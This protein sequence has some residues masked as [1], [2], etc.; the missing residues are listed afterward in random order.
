MRFANEECKAVALTGRGVA[1]RAKIRVEVRAINR[2]AFMEEA[3][4]TRWIVQIENGCLN[5]CVGRASAGRMQWIAF[6]L[7]RTPVHSRRDQRN[8]AGASG[9]GCRVVQKF[10]GYGPLDALRERHQMQF[11]SATTGQADSGE[12][13]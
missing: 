12:R 6:Q 1:Q 10:S 11:R 13:H 5:E 9:H 4:G 8:C 3:S 2:F 7:N